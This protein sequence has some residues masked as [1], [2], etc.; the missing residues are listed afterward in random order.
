MD[1]HA[2]R[3]EKARRVLY[4]NFTAYKRWI[5]RRYLH[6]PHLELF[7]AAL[8]ACARHVETGG[9]EGLEF[10]IVEMPPRHG[11]S[12]TLTR[13]F[14]TWF[15]GRNPDC[16]VMSVSYAASLAHKSSRYARNTMLSPRYSA[17]FPGVAL[18]PRSAAADAWDIDGHEGGMDALGVLGGATGKGSHLLLLDDLIKNRQEAESDVIRDRTW[19]ALTDDLLTRLEPGGAT[20]LNATR[21]HMDDPLGRALIQLVPNIPKRKFLHLC[22]PAIAGDQDPLGRQPG[23]ALWPQ[24]YPIERLRQIQL[25]L[26]EYSWSALYQQNPVPAEGGIFKRRWFYPLIQQVPPIVRAVR[27]WDLAMSEKTSADYTVGVKLGQATDGHYYVLD[28]ARRQIDWGDLTGYMAEVMLADGVDV[29]QGIEEKGYM[30]RAVQTLNADPRLHRYSIWG[31]PVDRDKVTRALPAAAKFAAGVIHVATAHWSELYIDELCSFPNGTHDDQV[32]AT[33]GAWAMMD[34]EA[35]I[36]A[37]ALH[38]DEPY[39]IANV[40]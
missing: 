3:A 4:Q 27:Y 33:S 21:W 32:D 30:S 35:G 26:G 23:E 11:K 16:R 37:G 34:D 10:L 15:L 1:S 40:Y 39:R 31:Y 29:S 2:A 14:P 9:R 24:R 22:F 5:Y 8:M 20:V 6:A 38:H 17:V 18:D 13:Y 19:D 28:V 25:Q 12:L 36:G 7:D